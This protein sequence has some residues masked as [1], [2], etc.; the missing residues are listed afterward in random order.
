[1]NLHAGAELDAHIVD[2]LIV[3]A[4]VAHSPENALYGKYADCDLLTELE[5]EHREEVHRL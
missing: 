4:P 2:G 5:T 1:L 3:L